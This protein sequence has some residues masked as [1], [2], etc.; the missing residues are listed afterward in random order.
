MGQVSSIVRD[1]EWSKA[2]NIPLKDYQY[3]M[4]NKWIDKIYTTQIG[5]DLFNC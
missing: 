1:I 4:T 5:I 2:G 3:K